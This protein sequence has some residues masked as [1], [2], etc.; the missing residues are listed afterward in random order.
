VSANIANHEIGARELDQNLRSRARDFDT[1]WDRL[2]PLIVE[3]RDRRIYGELGFTS[4]PQYIADVCQTEMPNVARVVDQRRP[5]VALLADEGMS[6][7]AIAAAVGV[8]EISVRRDMQSLRQD[9]APGGVTD[10]TPGQT[11][12]VEAAL[13]RARQGAAPATVTGI[14]GKTY[15]KPKPKPIVDRDADAIAASR[16]EEA[17]RIAARAVELSA[18]GKACDGLLAALS[19]AASSVPPKDTDRYPVVGTF[20]ER[21]RTLGNHISTWRTDEP[22]VVDVAEH[23][24]DGTTAKLRTWYA[25]RAWEY[26]GWDDLYDAINTGCINLGSVLAELGEPGVGIGNDKISQSLRHAKGV[27]L[28]LTRSQ[29]QELRD[30]LKS[31]RA[32]LIVLLDNRQDGGR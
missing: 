23:Q 19:F 17:M 27:N 18:W 12:R 3:A 4:W 2:E 1:A 7:R 24:G 15:S 31:L 16:E 14:D 21:Y 22:V 32:A 5:L 6:N 10:K 29:A 30:D 25:G 26:G 8:N 11:D 13:E 9:V 28:N 20:I